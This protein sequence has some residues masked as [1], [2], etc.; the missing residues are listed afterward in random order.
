MQ[1][2]PEIT[3]SISEALLAE[4]EEEAKTTR[5]VLSAVDGGRLDWKPH[6]KSMAVGALAGHIAEAPSWTKSMLEREF[7]FAT[8]VRDYRPFVPESV[9]DLLGKFDEN[10]AVFKE[11]FAG[12]DDAFMCETWEMKSD[13]A[14]LLSSPRHAAVRST[15]VHHIIHHRGQLTVYLRLLDIAVPMTYGPTADENPFPA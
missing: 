11:A 4:F 13:G 6:E 9:D 10:V 14:V 2:L 8:V 5:R 1:S 12:R 15:V 3:M 7:D